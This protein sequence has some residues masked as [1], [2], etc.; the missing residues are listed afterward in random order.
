MG[1]R[2]HAKL[3][4]PVKRGLLKLG[5]DLRDARRRRRIP[6]ALMA[7]R[8]G[9]S[10]STLAKAEKGDCTVSIGVYATIMFVLGLSERIAGLAD[11]RHDEVGLALEE[12]R[13][14]QRIWLKK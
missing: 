8:V 2:A 6:T 7:E 14:P 11:P 5:S 3:S 1:R 12:E 4:L 10:R 9:I 13:L